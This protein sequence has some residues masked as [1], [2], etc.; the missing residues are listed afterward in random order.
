MSE[1][2]QRARPLATHSKRFRELPSSRTPLYN[3]VTWLVCHL[4][5]TQQ[6]PDFSGCFYSLTMSHNS[7]SQELDNPIAKCLKLN[8]EQ[9]RAIKEEQNVRASSFTSAAIKLKY[10]SRHMVFRCW[11][12]EMFAAFKSHQSLWLSLAELTIAVCAIVSL[13]VS[14]VHTIGPDRVATEVQGLGETVKDLTK[15]AKRDHSTTL[16]IEIVHYSNLKSTQKTGVINDPNRY[17]WAGCIVYMGSV[18]ANVTDDTPILII[19]NIG[20]R[21]TGTG[22]ITGTGVPATAKGS[23]TPLYVGQ[24]VDN[25]HIRFESGRG[26]AYVLETRYPSITWERFTFDEGCDEEEDLANVEFDPKRF[27]VN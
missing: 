19:A 23:A 2:Y 5:I 24:I 21:S 9:T 18:P 15:L 27:G 12:K 25:N 1:R 20:S 26:N 17:S 8:N 10:V 3:V 11:F 6:V 22:C 13:V 14:L 7:K 16:L 4:R